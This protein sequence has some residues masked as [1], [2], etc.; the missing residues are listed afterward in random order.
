MSKT[1]AAGV[2]GRGTGRGRGCALS[3]QHCDVG[4]APL[5]PCGAVPVGVEPASQ[6]VAF[7]R[8][9][10]QVTSQPLHQ[11]AQLG[12][13]VLRLV[14]SPLQLRTTRQNIITPFRKIITLFRKII[15]LFRK[16]AT[17][18]WKKITLFWISKDN[19]ILE[20]ITLFCYFET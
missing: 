20:M 17:L 13:D 14:A 16:M 4:V 11:L 7:A 1:N 15:T 10:A 19:A 12:A 5:Q 2:E 8:H 9:G 3:P 18:F 6:L